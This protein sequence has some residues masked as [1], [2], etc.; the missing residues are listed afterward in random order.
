M[1]NSPSR[2]R[3]VRKETQN[4][5]NRCRVDS[6]RLRGLVRLLRVVCLIAVTGFALLQNYAYAAGTN[7]SHANPS[8]NIVMM[9]G[10]ISDVDGTEAAQAVATMP[11]PDLP[12]EDSGRVSVVTQV[13]FDQTSAELRPSSTA[14]TSRVMALAPL[15]NKA[16]SA[17][18]IDTAL[19]MAVIDVES[20][21]NPQAVSPK[22]ATGLMQ[23]MPGT[24][25][26]HGAKNLFDP[27]QNLAAGARYLRQ[28]MRQ[29]GDVQLA[30]AAYNAGEGAV[31]KYG[32][33]IPPYAETM[34]YVPKV[35]DRYRYYRSA[36]SPTNDSPTRG[37]FLQVRQADD[38]N[39]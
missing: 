1:Q 4:S 35:I 37:G 7:R 2:K 21:G 19:L 34:S 32:G 29:F 15:V 17:A 16:A 9:I 8:A 38:P 24:G 14:V 20:G 31:Q 26:R 28:L 12:S 39:E 11:M 3:T 23:L 33:Q 18:D 6:A 22:G 10:G 13:G 5:L 27:R 36:F 25:A 30:L